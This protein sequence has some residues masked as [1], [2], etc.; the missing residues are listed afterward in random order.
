V[1][2]GC[3][4]E[5]PDVQ[6]V[7]AG[8]HELRL[9]RGHRVLEAQHDAELVGG[10]LGVGV[11]A[12]LLRV[13]RLVHLVEALDD[14]GVGH[15]L[16][17]R[18]HAHP[19][20]DYVLNEVLPAL[21]LL[22]LLQTVGLQQPRLVDSQSVEELLVLG[23]EVDL[24]GQ[25]FVHE[26]GSRESVLE[27]HFGQE[28]LADDLVLE[29]ARVGVEEHQFAA[30]GAQFERQELHHECHRFALFDAHPVPGDEK[31]RDFDAVRRL[32]RG[33]VNGILFLLSQLFVRVHE[34]LDLEI[35]EL[36]LGPRENVADLE[37]ALLQLVELRLGLPNLL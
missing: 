23:R 26:G 33:G 36:E 13:V 10:L 17:H 8:A 9:Q 25:L 3:E 15:A 21:Q 37:L 1:D 22:L 5:H 31:R 4:F 30:L 20:A 7:L 11:L 19:E 12:L 29:L 6:A 14:V 2:G 27:H 24:L 16:R 18:R 32:A 34:Q 35:D 28:H